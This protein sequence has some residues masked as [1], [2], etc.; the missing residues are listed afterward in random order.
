MSSLE[1]GDV[2]EWNKATDTIAR[3]YFF[4]YDYRQELVANSTL[5]PKY[6][7]SFKAQIARADRSLRAMGECLVAARQIELDM[8]NP[9]LTLPELQTRTKKFIEDLDTKYAPNIG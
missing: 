4:L 9:N 1:E 2:N 8:M 6:W 5:I 3:N 7:D